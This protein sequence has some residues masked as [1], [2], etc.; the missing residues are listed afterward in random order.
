MSSQE[1]CQCL[2]KS[3]SAKIGSWLE[4]GQEENLWQRVQLD[5]KA[6][7]TPQVSEKVPPMPVPLQCPREGVGFVFFSEGHEE[8][9]TLTTE[10]GH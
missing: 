2:F 1:V 7:G 10:E 5:K 9:C 8:I 6:F 4:F 3:L